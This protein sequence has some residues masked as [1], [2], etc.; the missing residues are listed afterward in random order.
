MKTRSPS[1]YERYDSSTNAMAA[2]MNGW[3]GDGNRYVGNINLKP[4]T[5]HTLSVTYD[6]HDGGSY[7]DGGGNGD[8]QLKVTPY[9]SY[10]EDYIDVRRCGRLIHS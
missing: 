2:K 7:K 10:V 5:A 6:V 3:A 4:E 9:Y 8:W 1:L